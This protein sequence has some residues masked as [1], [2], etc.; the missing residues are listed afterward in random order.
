MKVA[1]F[2]HFTEGR[3]WATAA[4]NYV[5]S[6]VSVG[7]DV[8]CRP[9][10]IGGHRQPSPDIIKLCNKSIAGTTHTIQHTMPNFWDHSSKTKNVG[11]FVTET[12]NITYTHWENKLKI[13]DQVWVPN[14]QMQVEINIP[15]RLIPHATDISVYAKEYQR[16]HLPQF[17]YK[18]AFYFV[19]ENI[20]RKRINALLTAYYSEFDCNDDVVMIIKTGKDG[21]SADDTAR[22][23]RQ[24]SDTIKTGLR[25][26]GKRDLY[27]ELVIIPEHM[28]ADELYGLHQYADCFVNASFGDAWNQP[29][30][31]ALG[32]GNTII[33]PLIGGMADYLF[34]AIKYYPVK[35]NKEV[36][37]GA[38]PFLP[39]LHTAREN[40]YAVNIRDL[41]RQMRNAF[42]S[43]F[44]KNKVPQHK[45][46]AKRYSYENV[47][48]I[49]LEC[50]EK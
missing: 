46:F 18:Y 16:P 8:V 9:I 10:I 13:M 31:D 20:K 1:Y 29:C 41:A 3:G 23:I 19:G 35:C 14:T 7:V 49:M 27:P 28:P 47:G 32:F 40:W 25:M 21:Q 48:K 36:C 30:F 34:G 38:D 12:D 33:S 37:F 50:L 6:L 4:E 26:Y 2:G 39:D 11:L 45:E 17:Q 24:T 42:Q 22:D 43:D 44:L 15:T 5:R